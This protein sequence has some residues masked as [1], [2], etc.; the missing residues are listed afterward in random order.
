MI[1]RAFDECALF[2]SASLSCVPER[3]T[4]ASVPQQSGLG[5]PLHA[6]T[7]AAEIAA[8]PVAPW[9]TDDELV[10]LWPH[11]KSPN[12]IRAYGE[13]VA[14]FRAFRQSTRCSFDPSCQPPITRKEN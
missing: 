2:P 14:A 8:L 12:T 11:G 13:D 6:P 3:T 5:A 9:T 7:E 4:A 1:E 10:A